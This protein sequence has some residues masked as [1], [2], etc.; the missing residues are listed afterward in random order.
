MSVLLSNALPVFTIN[1]SCDGWKST[2]WCVW[3]FLAFFI[4]FSVSVEASY[5][6]FLQSL[7]LPCYFIGLLLN[8]W[9]GA[10]VAATALDFRDCWIL[11]NINQL[12]FFQFLVLSSIFFLLFS[13]IHST[14]LRIDK[15]FFFSLKEVKIRLNVSKNKGL[16]VRHWN[17]WTN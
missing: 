10:I 9:H 13:L 4:P 15:S 17:W 7:F 5:P 16:N 12:L 2:F 6:S 14:F 3:Y 8:T 1:Y 11:L